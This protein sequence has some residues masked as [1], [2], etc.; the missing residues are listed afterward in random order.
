[1]QKTENEEA[2]CEINAPLTCQDHCNNELMVEVVS[3]T[4]PSPCFDTESFS[5]YEQTIVNA[6]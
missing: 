1:M 5:V 4:R 3:H 6:Q 2:F